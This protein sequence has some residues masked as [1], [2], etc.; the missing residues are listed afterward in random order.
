MWLVLIFTFGFLASAFLLMALAGD[1]RATPRGRLLDLGP[2]RTLEPASPALR[3]HAAGASDRLVRPLLRRMGRLGE[4]LGLAKDARLIQEKLDMAGRPRLFGVAVGARE[5][6][7]LKVVCITL[8]L[9]FFAYTMRNPVADGIVGLLLTLILTVGIFMAPTLVVDRKIENR[10]RETLRSLSDVLDLLVVSAEAGLSLD[11][12]MSRVAEKRS[13]P[14][15]EEFEMALSEMR[16]GVS[17]ADALRALARRTGVMEVK[18]FAS[19][20]I[21]AEG[22]GVSISQVLRSQAETNRERRSQRVREQAA[23]LATKM[24]FPLV[25]FILPAIFVVMAAPGVIQI[26]RALGGP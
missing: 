9:F 3:G 2:A 20:V 5:F 1:A 26:L 7:A 17:R 11:A 4:R 24:L 25:F 14:L 15:P 21:Q 8:A 18:A 6:I 16:L 13:G 10:Q 19:A 22:L 12:A 23:K